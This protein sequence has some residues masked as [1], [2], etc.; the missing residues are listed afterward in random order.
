MTKATPI[1]ANIELGLAYRLRGS[2]YYHHA[3]KQGSMQ[4]DMV[5]EEPRVLHLD[6]QATS[7]KLPCALGVG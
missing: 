6:L 5:L 1:K 2:V 7:R 3:G 4:A